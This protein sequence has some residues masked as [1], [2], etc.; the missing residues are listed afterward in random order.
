MSNEGNICS[1][2]APQLLHRASSPFAISIVN[3][4]TTLTVA[5]I[6]ALL[7]GSR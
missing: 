4:Q 2:Y 7:G 5:A 1:T 6:S 3:P